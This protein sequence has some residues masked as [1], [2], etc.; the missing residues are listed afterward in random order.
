MWSNPPA[1][2]RDTHSSISVLRVL[3]PD[4]GWMKGWGTTA[5]LSASVL[6][7]P[8][9]TPCRGT[10]PWQELLAGCEVRSALRTPS[11][12]P[13]GPPRSPYGRN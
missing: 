6:P 2:H 4:L 9:G 13:R 11:T 7:G 10:A 8:A 5:S 3:S 12:A 1:A